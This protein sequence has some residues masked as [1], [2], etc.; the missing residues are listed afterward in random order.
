LNKAH[1]SHR[2]EKSDV[3]IEKAKK[4]IAEATTKYREEHNLTD[5]N[6]SNNLFFIMS[7]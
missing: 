7:R 2:R 4:E 1:Y 6:V 3:N 5:E